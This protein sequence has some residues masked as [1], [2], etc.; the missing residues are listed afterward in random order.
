MS[1]STSL[2]NPILLG[3]FLVDDS[4][5]RLHMCWKEGQTPVANL[6]KF[7]WE[8]LA[9]PDTSFTAEYQLRHQPYQGQVTAVLLI[10]CNT[11]QGRAIL[12][13][14]VQKST[15]SEDQLYRG[16]GRF[17]IKCPQ[18]YNTPNHISPAQ[19]AAY[20]DRARGLPVKT[21]VIV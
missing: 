3:G 21:F 14:S 10:D 8:L 19:L 16:V 13:E 2:L 20:E 7:V 15:T 17:D 6:T 12:V 4:Q 5:L 18:P 1:E 11:I 9:Q